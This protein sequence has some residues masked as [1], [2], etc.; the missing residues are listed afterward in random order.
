MPDLCEKAAQA[1]PD[2]LYVGW[3]VLVTPGF[4]KAYLLEG[5]AFGDLLPNVIHAGRST[6]TH[7]IEAIRQLPPKAAFH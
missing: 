1:I 6:Y 2:A 7:G 4:R 3:D 5:N